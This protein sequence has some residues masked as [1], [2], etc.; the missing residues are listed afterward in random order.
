MVHGALAAAFLIAF[1]TG[2][3]AAWIHVPAG[4]TV[5][6]LASLGLLALAVSLAPRPGRVSARTAGNARRGL[7]RGAAVALLACLT[8]LAASGLGTWLSG[9]TAGAW[10]TAHEGLRFAAMALLGAHMVGVLRRTGRGS[11]SART[12]AG[13]RHR[14]VRPKARGTE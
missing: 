9:N 3:H 5:G 6:L 14:A 13:T 8:G 4:I 2:G 11:A 12:V 10:M 7:A 1:A